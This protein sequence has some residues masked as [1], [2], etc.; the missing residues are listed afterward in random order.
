MKLRNA[1]GEQQ[2]PCAN[3]P[4]A[5]FLLAKLNARNWVDCWSAL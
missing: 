4:Y 1:A 5:N 3:L 2:G